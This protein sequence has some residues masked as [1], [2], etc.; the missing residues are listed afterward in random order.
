MS[1]SLV[2]MAIFTLSLPVH[3]DNRFDDTAKVISVNPEIER[4]NYPREECWTEHVYRPA[5]T[6]E[7]STAGAI[8]GGVTGAVIGAQVGKGTGKTAATAAGAITGAIVGERM[9]SDYTRRA[10]PEE[11]LHCRTIDNWQERV[12]GY[13]VTYEYRGQTFTEIMSYDPGVGRTIDVM[14]TVIPR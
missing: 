12:L 3:A 4:V 8:I 10:D 5:P 6:G 7:R 11:V 13:R 9:G 2:A 14:V 1:K